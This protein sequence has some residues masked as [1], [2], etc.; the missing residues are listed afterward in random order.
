MKTYIRDFKLMIRMPFSSVVYKFFANHESQSVSGNESKGEIL[1]LKTSTKRE[2]V[3]CPPRLQSAERCEIIHLQK[4][5]QT[6]Q[7]KIKA[8]CVLT[9]KKEPHCIKFLSMDK[10]LIFLKDQ[11]KPADAYV[12]N[13]KKTQI[14]RTYHIYHRQNNVIQNINTTK[15]ISTTCQTYNTIK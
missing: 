8:V 10:L 15:A 11:I 3:L 2:K 14:T 9:L 1:F 13:G 7:G 6:G 12:T 4:Y 5:G